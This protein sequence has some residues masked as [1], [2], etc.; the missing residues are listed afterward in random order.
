MGILQLSC[1]KKMQRI[2]Y[3]SLYHQGVLKDN[4]QEL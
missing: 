2:F 3:F 4:R 1:H